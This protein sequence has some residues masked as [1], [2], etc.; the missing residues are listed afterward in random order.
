MNEGQETQR[1]ETALID[2]LKKLGAT[3]ESDRIN[4]KG[5]YIIQFPFENGFT[6]MR[7]LL[8]DPSGADL[9]ISHINTQPNNERNKGFGALALQQVLSWARENMLSNIRTVQVQKPSENFWLK[10]G[11]V[12]DT[13]PNPTN[14]FVYRGGRVSP[15]SK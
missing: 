7:I 5:A 1:R 4:V 10:N 9:V 6:F 8:N 3:I 11:F 12:K 14:D 15:D 2:S 13:D